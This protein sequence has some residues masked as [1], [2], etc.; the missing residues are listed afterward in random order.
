[1]GVMQQKTLPVKMEDLDGP[2]AKQILDERLYP[3]LRWSRARWLAR[4]LVCFSTVWT[5]QSS[6]S[7]TMVRRPC[8]PRSRRR[9]LFWRR[10]IKQK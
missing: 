6:Y 3:S 2:E 9:W 1:M 4:S 8:S 10:T 5:T 7:E